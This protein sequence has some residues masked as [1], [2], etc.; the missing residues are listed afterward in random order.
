[1]RLFRYEI[2]EWC[3]TEQRCSVDLDLTYVAFC[4]VTKSDLQAVH[5][6][7]IARSS[8]TLNLRLCVYN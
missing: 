4:F 1:M 2:I 3:L 6:E 5:K 8:L 7:V